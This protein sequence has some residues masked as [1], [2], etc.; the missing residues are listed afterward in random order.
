MRFQNLLIAALLV[1]AGAALAQANGAG[2]PSAIPE[3]IQ[4]QG[5][6]HQHLNQGLAATQLSQRQIKR[7]QAQDHAQ[8]PRQPVSQ[9]E[10]WLTR[11]ERIRRLN[12]AKVA[13]PGAPAK[14]DAT[15]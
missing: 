5:L 15:P 9:A 7:L 13:P 6:Q 8:A 3:L 12:A 10:V 4:R 2:Q 14:G 1:S 11:Q